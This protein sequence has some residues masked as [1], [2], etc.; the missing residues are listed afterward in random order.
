MVS[1]RRVL[2]AKKDRLESLSVDRFTNA[3]ALGK[4]NK[5]RQGLNL[6]EL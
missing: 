5:F 4:G 3:D 2:L 6:V 1:R